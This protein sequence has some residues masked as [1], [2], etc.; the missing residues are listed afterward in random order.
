MNKPNLVQYG[1]WETDAND[2]DGSYWMLYDTLEDAVS[3]NGDGTVVYKLEAHLVG[4]FKRSV[5][6]QR[7][8]K[9]KSKAKRKAA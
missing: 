1:V 5:V 7:I 6:V 8:P 3:E 9:R 4:T 2:A